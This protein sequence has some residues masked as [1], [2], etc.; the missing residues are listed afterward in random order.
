MRTGMWI[1]SVLA[2]IA[3]GPAAAQE[4]EASLQ[5]I[6]VS[7]AGFDI[8]VAM[9]KV[10][11]E[12]IDLAESPDALVLHL[13]GGKLAL[14]FE[15]VEAMMDAID[16]LRAPVGAL[17]VHHR[18]SGAAGCGLYRSEDPRDALSFRRP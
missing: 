5:R 4:Q 7:S 3:G 1:C 18:G 16:T 12:N 6:E 10:P 9:S 15:S 17:S 13:T 11:A 14:G 8:L 2:V